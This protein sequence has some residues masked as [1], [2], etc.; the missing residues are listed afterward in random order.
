MQGKSDME[1][2]PPMVHLNGTSRDDLLDVRE[3]AYFALSEAFD[4]LRQIAPNG[5]DYYPY[6]PGA[7][8]AAIDLNMSR[9]AAVQKVID[10]LAE[11]MVAIVHQ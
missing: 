2:K 10:G 6:G 3:K 7:L 5:R 9:M 4:A 11:E 1:A 8:E